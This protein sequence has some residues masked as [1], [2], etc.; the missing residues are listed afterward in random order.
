MQL[1]ALVI[2]KLKELQKEG[3]SGREQVNQYTRMLSIPLAV[4]QSISV[5]VLLRSQG[6]LTAQDPFTIIAMVATLVAGAA[7]VMWLGELIT[8]YGA[9]NGI[10]MILLAGIISQ[11]PLMIAQMGLMTSTDQMIA[12][13]FGVIVA[14]AVMMFVV[15]MN[16]AVRRVPIQYARR[17]RGSRSYGGQQ[18]FLPIKVNVTGVLPII[19]AVTLMILPSFAAQLFVGTSVPFLQ[20]LG[21]WL[22]VHFSPTSSAYTITYFLIVFVFT[23]F[24]AVVFFNADDL[25]KELKK[26]GAY[27][28]GIRPG[29]PT[30][31]YLEFVVTRITLAGA[32]FL[33][34]IAILPIIAQQ[35][36]GLQSL[37]VGGTSVLI[38]VSV[39]LET[40]KQLQSHLLEHN[41][42]KYV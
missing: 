13:G 12:L 4:F 36:T 6:L 8:L 42:D 26:S 27:V 7:V 39:I 9:G 30:K 11:L 24:S 34:L 29:A 22:L 18:S 20:Q 25:S 31:K 14:L 32:V 3:E 15:F 33:G 10:S 41:Y 5:L 28:P 19:F 40:S 37:A 35:L 21:Q 16:E 17:I 2:P 1:T 38:V 23:Y